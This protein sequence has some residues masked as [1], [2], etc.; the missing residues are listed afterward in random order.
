MARRVATTT[1]RCVCYL[2]HRRCKNPSMRKPKSIMWNPGSTRKPVQEKQRFSFP[3][4]RHREQQERKNRTLTRKRKTDRKTR[5]S[6]KLRWKTK[7]KA[8]ATDVPAQP[9]KVHRTCIEATTDPSKKW[10]QTLMQAQVLLRLFC[11][12]FLRRRDA[13]SRAPIA[14]ARCKSYL[15]EPV[16]AYE[17]EY[18]LPTTTGNLNRIWVMIGHRVTS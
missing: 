4:D 10:L 14:R 16:K 13:S 7:R 15:L 6:N 11:V 2:P 17:K 9:E 12:C 8:T 1:G 5:D 3:P 18:G